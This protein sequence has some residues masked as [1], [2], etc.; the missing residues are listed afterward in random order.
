[1]LS[2]RLNEFVY[3]H[4]TGDGECNGIVLTKWADNHKLNKKDRIDLCYFFAITY[5]VE[6]AIVLYQ[7][8]NEIKSDMNSWVEG[9]K[10]HIIFQSDRKYIRMQDSFQRCLQTWISKW[11]VLQEI[12]NE[13]EIDFKK[14]IPKIET[15]P[16]FGRFSAYLYLE[17]IAWLLG[18][19]VINTEMDWENGATATSGLLHIYGDDAAA[20]N[21]DK[22]RKLK[23]PYSQQK[24]QEI[25]E[26]VLEAIRKAGGDDNITKVETSLCAYR[27]FFKGTRYNGYY[28]DRMLEEILSMR[29][30]YPEI[31]EELMKIRATT[32]PNEL[33]G[34][35]NN[36]KGV[37][38]SEKKACKAQH[39]TR[40]KEIK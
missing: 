14:W 16:L 13:I 39:P 35:S 15:Y 1:M 37:R 32:F 36:W 22:S 12:S 7:N 18:M 10:E 26:P 34:E 33:L 20:E 4:N 6:S 19:K 24:L 5:C 25:C 29:K 3:Y 30:D 31:S 2:R 38:S 28:L 23:K 17:T 8:R 40:T 9:N 21:Y 11:D 27:K